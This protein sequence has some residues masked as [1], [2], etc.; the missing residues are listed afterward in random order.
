VDVN[1]ILK[2][3][4]LSGLTISDDEAVRFGSQLDEVLNYMNLLNEVEFSGEELVDKIDIMNVKGVSSLR[5][6]M[7]FES[8]TTNEVTGNAPDKE[9][10]F[11][12]VVK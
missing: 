1:V 5:D 7:V 11:I 10:G 8:Q 12:K 6:D 4:R 9:A 3:A 2:C